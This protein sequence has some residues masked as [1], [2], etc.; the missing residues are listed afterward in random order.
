MADEIKRV[1]DML[2]APM[3]QVI[4]SLGTGIA[5]AQRELDRFALESQR[6]IAEDPLLADTGLTGTFYQIPVAEL[7]LT[8]AIALEEEPP[9]ATPPASGT[10]VRA[11]ILRQIHLQPVNA[12]YNNHFS[13]DVNAASKLKL[14]LVPVP[15]PGGEGVAP[16]LTRDKVLDIAKPKLTADADARLSANFNGQMR[17]WFVLQYRFEGDTVKRLAL[18]VVDDATGQIIK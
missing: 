14:K 6:E 15:P 2:S 12:S 11:P 13:F 3:E 9:P 16:S 5:R 7:E 4:V 8:M 1:T 18:V 10:L 17:T